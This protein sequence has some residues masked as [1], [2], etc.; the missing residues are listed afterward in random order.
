MFHCK[1]SVPIIFMLT[2]V[3]LPLCAHV[4]IGSTDTLVSILCAPRY[5]LILYSLLKLVEIR[6]KREPLLSQPLF[7]QTPTDFT[8]DG[9]GKGG[10]LYRSLHWNWVISLTQTFLLRVIVILFELYL[11]HHYNL[12]WML[13]S[14]ALFLKWKGRKGRR[15]GPIQA[16]DSMC[17]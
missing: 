9:L 17:W 2:C 13:P 8:N 4:P 3:F 5:R 10:I 1:R 15:R 7:G 16:W 11:Y 12:P 6:P 14:K